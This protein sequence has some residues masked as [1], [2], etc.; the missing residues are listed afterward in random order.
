MNLHAALAWI[1][2]L[3]WTLLV[4]AVIAVGAVVG[5]G[6]HYIG[7]LERYQ[8]PLL[9]ELSRRSG[10]RID[11]DRLHGSWH[12]VV[13]QI[14]IDNLRIGAATGDEP[15]LTLQRLSLQVGLFRSL[16][17]RTLVLHRVAGEG[18][19]FALEERAPGAWRLR[20]QRDAGGDTAFDPR[21]LQALLLAV[22]R[23]NIDAV[24]VDAHFFES[25]T[26]HLRG[27]LRLERSG[28]FRRLAFDLRVDDGS[29]QQAAGAAHDSG[30]SGGIG[31]PLK[32]TLELRGDP[33]RPARAE[34]DLYA[35]FDD[36]DLA[37]LLPAARAFGVDLRHGRIDGRAWLSWRNGVL[38]ARGRVAA[39]TIELAALTGSEMAA[40]QQFSAAFDLEQ[41]GQHRQLWLHDLQVQWGERP[42]Q[43]PQLWLRRDAEEPLQLALP[44]L[45]LAELRDALLA[46]RALP[47]AALEL[48]RALA[49]AGALQDLQLRLP[50]AA[51]ER[52][53]FALRARFSDV[54]IEPWHDAP[55]VSGA[56]G[57][58]ELGAD[59]GHALLDSRD[60]AVAFPHVFAQPLQFASARAAVRWQSADGRTRLRSGAIELRGAAGEA[61]AQ[62]SL[63]LAH[64]PG[65]IA[66]RMDLLVA[67]RGSG[68]EHRDTFLPQT[69]DADLLAWLKR[70]VVAGQLPRGAYL[71]RGSLRP[72]DRANR[73][74]QLYLQIDG[75]ELAYHPQ[76]P[77]LRELRGALWLDDSRVRV[78]GIEARM[79]D[80]VSV[81]GVEVTLAPDSGGGLWLTVAGPGRARDDDLLRLLRETPLRERIG[82]QLDRWQWR[83]EAAFD[84]AL[85][86]AIGG[87]R[88]PQVAVEA[89]LGPGQLRLNDLDLTFERLAGPLRYRSATGLASEGLAATLFGRP[90]Q[91][92]VTSARDGAVGVDIR[93][94]LAVADLQDRL[95][96]E[97]AKQVNGETDLRVALSLSPQRSTLR[98]TSSLQGIA[99]ALPPPYAKRADEALPLRVEMR[100]DGTRSLYARLAGWATLDLRWPADA[101]AAVAPA[102]VETPK[103]EG[104]QTKLAARLQLGD[105]QT[106][107][108]P[109]FRSGRLV[110]GG[111]LPPLRLADWQPLL[112]GVAGGGESVVELSGLRIAELQVGALAL[113]ELHLDGRGRDDGWLLNAR[114]ERFD[115]E[116]LLPRD[117]LPWRLHLR[118]LQLPAPDPARAGE[119]STALA[120]IDPRTLPALD[121]QID[122]LWRGEELWGSVGFALRPVSHG[123]TARQLRGELRGLRFGEPPAAL[124]WLR[125]ERG[126]RTFFAGRLAVGDL[127]GVLAQW[128]FEPAVVTERG[129][130]DADVSWSGRPDQYALRLLSGEATLALRDGQLLTAGGSAEGAIKLVGIFNVANLLRR[131][132][133]DFSDLFRDGIP[134]D[135]LDARLALREGRV[136]LAPKPLVIIGP[137]S[138]FRASGMIDFN[139]DQVEMSLTATLPLAGNLP[140]IAAL[141]GG[142]PVAAGVFVASKVLGDQVDRFSSAVYSITGSWR[143][144]E[145]KLSQLFDP[146]SDDRAPTPPRRTQ[147]AKP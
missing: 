119:P 67:L 21:A 26:A 112:G 90:L 115:G 19:R 40:L 38:N 143:E 70:A 109:P 98:A 86:F 132:Q 1:N 84:L 144:P 121:L 136:E 63:D 68:V 131:L 94:R 97:A 44:R 37:P 91:A 9:A 30:A 12:G 23:A 114:A 73:T 3:L 116:L 33:R 92:T 17:E 61:T 104:Q 108:P 101:G 110:I 129:Q 113:R 147:G 75:G 18:V 10:Y 11:A 120:E 72:G 16:K 50:L 49:P 24:D 25:G 56:D 15:L 125:D 14:D 117:N 69:L 76:W 99:I 100:L 102:A 77:P 53:R 118:R 60:V 52:D 74:S 138:R 42:L 58:L 82:P 89:E 105:P 71:Y 80:T 135:R 28:R 140:W 79:F 29:A 8:Q 55:G 39:D 130:L 145:V 96:A 51:G 20:G 45:D 47:P 62:V 137:S 32:A 7:Y 124:T 103:P 83:G 146:R 95:P 78:T 22:R 64:T 4:C 41:R 141:A 13:P 66:S 5:L 128:G 85:G 111:T 36:L 43:L 81:D 31:A 48:V 34:A 126:D 123:A 6:R 106:D 107:A 54:A 2:R 59:G 87:A 93:G 134:F 57:F 127:A 65:E 35:E 27:G 122:E 88:P 133:L 142:L 46:A 139:S